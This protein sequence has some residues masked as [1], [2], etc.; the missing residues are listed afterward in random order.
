MDSSPLAGFPRPGKAL[1]AVLITIAVAGLAN[2][3][4]V[5]WIPGGMVVFKWLTFQ[6]PA[7]KTGEWWRLY[8][9]FTSGILT[10]PQTSQGIWQLLFT[11]IGLY[12]LSPD[13]ERRWGAWRFVRFLF[14][15]VIAGSLLVLAFDWIT[16]E[17]SEFFHQNML[18]GAM[19][20]ITG[21]AVA[22]GRENPSTVVRLFF[23]LPMSGKWLL[24]ITIGFSSLALLY[25]DPIS[26]GR[27]APFGGVL[28][29]L[30]LSGSPS[31]IRRAYLHTKLWF[32]RRSGP[33][34]EVDASG[35]IKRRSG[36]PLR[37]VMGG[38]A[39]EKDPP[40]DKRYLN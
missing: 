36:P 17:T 26:E 25:K 5:N 15:S 19:A 38:A 29:G 39:E 30:L 35:R 33:R 8:A 40:K 34:V 13:L 6:L 24:W 37:V 23:F 18:F 3:L 10:L 21:T 16:P 31:A 27:L 32:L 14:T 1:K 28:V 22:W 9:L 2:A 7:I 12:F 11:L 20:A 4:L